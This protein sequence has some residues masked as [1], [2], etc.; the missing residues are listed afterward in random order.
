MAKAEIEFT[1]KSTIWVKIVVLLCK[2]LNSAKPLIWFK[3]FRVANVY[4]GKTKL[5]GI[6]FKDI[7]HETI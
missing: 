4:V 5:K 6:Y 7:C 3:N 1:M 2:T